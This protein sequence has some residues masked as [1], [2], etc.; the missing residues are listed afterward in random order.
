ML[1]IFALLY[2]LVNFLIYAILANVILSLIVQFM[3]Q[4]GG[5]VH[6]IIMLLNTVVAQITE[7]V[8]RPIRRL[9]PST[10]MLDFSPLIASI[11][12]TIIETAL[13]SVV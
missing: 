13:K 7:P 1:F 11:V 3:M 12:L 10:G 2:G 9:L 6:P 5:S 8:L 4:R